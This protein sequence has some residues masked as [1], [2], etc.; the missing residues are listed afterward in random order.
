MT[1]SS[2]IAGTLPHNGKYSNRNGQ[3]IIRMLQHHWAGT[4]G[5]IERLTGP[6]QASANYIITSDGKIYGQVPEEFRA[7]TSGSFEAD[8]PSITIEVQNSGVQVNGNDNDPQS[9]PITQAAYN[10]IV[11]LTADCAKRYKWGGVAFGNYR[12]HREFYQ[13]ACPGGYIWNRMSYIRASA[14]A[15]AVGSIVPAGS[16]PAPAP[17]TPSIK[18]KSIWTLA[19]ETIKGIYGSGDVRVKALGSQ[20]AAVQAEVNRILAA[21]KAKLPAKKSIAQL[22]DEVIAGVWG[23]GP[24]RQRRLGA[25]YAAV[26]AE[27]NRRLGASRPKGPS[28]S[29]LADAVLRGEYGDGPERQRRLGGNYAAVQ[30]EI[31]RRYGL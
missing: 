3:P 10:S 30:A 22:A 16:T 31:N 15:I 26:Q 28:I 11:A 23:S 17:A 1:F 8:A 19:Q 13:T 14:N 21:P 9:W 18:G 20:Y 29:Q 25:N 27:V 4:G 24:D 6:D 7:W 5:G 12:G 2:L